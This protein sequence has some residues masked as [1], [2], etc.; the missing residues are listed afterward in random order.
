MIT[1][2]FID[3]ADLGKAGDTVGY[4]RLYRPEEI[5]AGLRM[6]LHMVPCYVLDLASGSDYGGC[7]VTRSNY[8]ILCERK[9]GARML[10]GSHGSYGILYASKRAA[11]IVAAELADYP[12]LDDDNLSDLEYRLH[13][14]AWD[15]Y[16]ADD[17]RRALVQRDLVSDDLEPNGAQLAAIWHDACDRYNCG[18]SYQIETGCTVYYNVDRVVDRIAENHDQWAEQLAQLGAK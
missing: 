9:M 11:E 16:G 5:G 1:Q 3:K 2:Y 15:S 14:E 10:R 18:E 4:S 12:S 17:F 6:G 7:S 13:C 8:E